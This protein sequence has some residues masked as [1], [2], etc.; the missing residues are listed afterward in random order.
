MPCPA[1]GQTEVTH[2]FGDGSRTELWE[3][4][5]MELLLAWPV[6]MVWSVGPGMRLPGSELRLGWGVDR[7]RDKKRQR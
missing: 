4:Y 3:S 2:L 5:S 1:Q 7:G 6:G